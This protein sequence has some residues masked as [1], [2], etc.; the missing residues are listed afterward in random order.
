[1][2]YF[3]P[4]TYFFKSF[5]K[6]FTRK[7]F[8]VLLIIICLFLG[9]IL[10]G[11]SSVF[12]MGTYNV[13][14]S[15]YST[16]TI[17]YIDKC[18]ES[19]KKYFDDNDIDFS[20]FD[21]YMICSWGTSSADGIIDFTET[22]K[23]FR[24]VVA[25]SN[26]SI[27]TRHDGCF[28]GTPHYRFYFT[29]NNTDFDDVIYASSGSEFG[30][31]LHI[32]FC[33]FSQ[34][35]L[36]TKNDNDSFFNGVNGTVIAPYFITTNEELQTFDFDY[37]QI[38]GGSTKYYSYFEPLDK[39]YTPD[40]TL[41]Y[42]YKGVVTNIDILPEYVAINNTKNTWQI[43]IP[44]NVLTNKVI[45]RNGETFYYV[46]N[47]SNGYESG[48]SIKTADLTYDLTTEQEQ[49]INEDSEKQVQGEILQQQQQANEKLD[50]VDKS[51]QD[52]NSSLNDS[53]V[54]DS[55]INDFSGLSN[56]F[57]TED[58]TGIDKL[59]Q[60]LYDAFCSNEIQ[61]VSLTIPFVN[62]TFTINTSNVSNNFPEPVKNIVGVFV[63]GV[64][65]LW[66]LKDVRSIINK[67]SEGSPENVGS[68]V[69]KEVL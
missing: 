69:K 29:T 46:F 30:S 35:N 51:V 32:Y 42:V 58:N 60:I 52:L 65:G 53:D 12:A 49:S 56:G 3:N 41:K 7:F 28:N 59:F 36:V 63:W 33:N 16:E 1:M 24:I 44:Y 47:Y 21:R 50:N 9:F 13:D 68:D 38:N 6:L 25:K 67:I 54:D 14:T 37:L 4:I 22:G 23:N 48:Y 66:V 31:Y 17:N 18:T 2:D 11:N 62:K 64:I 45:V 61:D 27:S 26:L 10:F 5:I 57:D 20:Q 19:I 55:N 15:N 34:S 40:F 8:W 43:N 39:T